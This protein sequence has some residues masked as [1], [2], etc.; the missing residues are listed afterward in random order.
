MKKELPREMMIRDRERQKAL[1]KKE[2]LQKEKVK[3]YRP[4]KLERNKP[5]VLPRKKALR[6]QEA[7]RRG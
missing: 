1:R 5:I 4:K 6:K 7:L 2:A 3:H